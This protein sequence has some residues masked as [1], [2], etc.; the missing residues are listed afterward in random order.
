MIVNL[1]DIK[2]QTIKEIK[3]K[4]K[5]TSVELGTITLDQAVT[6]LNGNGVYLFGI[7]VEN[8]WYPLYVGKSSSRTFFERFAGHFD[9][10][11]VGTFNGLI[12]RLSKDHPDQWGNDLEKTA[13]ELMAKGTVV[14]VLVHSNSGA[15]V[16]RKLENILISAFAN[17]GIV[18]KIRKSASGV[19]NSDDCVLSNLL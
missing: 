15:D 2:D 4:L 9:T 13:K 5:E 6:T 10:R 3:K 1:N 7:K 12:K 11:V 14:T 17:E 8:D 18:N 19:S 16:C